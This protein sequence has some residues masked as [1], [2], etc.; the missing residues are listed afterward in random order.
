MFEG[1]GL[2]SHPAYGEVK[3]PTLAIVR[4]G[5]TNPFLPPDASEEL[6]S[7]ANTYYVE[8]FLPHVQRRTDLFREA[9]PHA[10]IVELDTS[11]HTLFVA[12]EDE[13]VEAIVDFLG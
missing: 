6:R 3:V 11:N 5:S 9:A 4:G 7:A 2:H 1:M 13:T 10:R 12:K 8:K